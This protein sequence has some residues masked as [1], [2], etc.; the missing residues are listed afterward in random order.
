[1]SERVTLKIAA[2]RVG[3]G[4]DI[5]KR[6]V[7]AGKISSQKD[8]MGRHTVLMDDVLDYYRRLSELRP[9]S[10]GS[11]QG[12]SVS[13]SSQGTVNRTVPGEHPEEQGMIIRTLH[14][15]IQSLEK[16][17]ERERRELERERSINDQLRG[18]LT[19]LTAE[20]VAYLHRTHTDKP[21]RWVASEAAAEPVPPLK[22]KVPA[23]IHGAV[24]VQKSKAVKQSKTSTKIPTKK[25][26]KRTPAKRSVGTRV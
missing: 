23:K 16:D 8:S 10:A 19:K 2:Q 6:H 7:T 13:T 3:R 21:S 14:D 15:R 5:I 18:D 11:S 26:Q 9:S 20:L 12:Q 17:L 25:N 22:P 4:L 24:A 1:M